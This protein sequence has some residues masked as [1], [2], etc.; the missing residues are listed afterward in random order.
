MIDVKTNHVTTTKKCKVKHGWPWLHERFQMKLI[1]WQSI[2]LISE[3]FI[4]IKEENLVIVMT[5]TEIG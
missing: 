2:A 5:L 3:N 1:N 4:K